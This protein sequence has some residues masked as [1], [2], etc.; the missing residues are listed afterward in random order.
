[1]SRV[2]KVCVAALLAAGTL[3]LAAPAD[4]AYDGR[5]ERSGPR[6]WLE[7]LFGTPRASKSPALSVATSDAKTKA[8]PT[9][10]RGRPGKPRR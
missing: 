2:R 5:R 10:R 4:A 8:S 7:I 1:M 6:E 3:A 9:D